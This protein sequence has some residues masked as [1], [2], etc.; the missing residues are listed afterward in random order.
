[1]ADPM[2]AAAAEAVEDVAVRLIG[3]DLGTIHRDEIVSAGIAAAL[4]VTADE[5]DWSCFADGASVISQLVRERADGL[6]GID[7]GGGR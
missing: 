1:M 2:I 3:R 4:R 7:D 5:I 6:A